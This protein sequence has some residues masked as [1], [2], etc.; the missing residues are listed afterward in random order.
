MNRKIMVAGV[1]NVFLGDDGFGVE[2]ARHLAEESFP[3]GVSVVDFGIRGVH[4]AYE[5]LDGYDTLVLIDAARRGE[6]PGTLFVLEP[7][8]AGD[9]DRG[10]NG[11]LLDAHSMDPELVLGILESLGGKIARVVIVGCEPQSISEDMGLSEVV[12]RAVPNAA[13]L[14]HEIIEKELEAD[15]APPR[16]A[17][18]AVE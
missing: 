9:G 15:T 7:D 8:F 12:T 3:D 5:L 11:F 6:P 18:G 2:V 10:E 17:L 1:G 16:R 4:L 14:V 13:R